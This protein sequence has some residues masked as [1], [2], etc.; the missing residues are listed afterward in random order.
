MPKGQF[1]RIKRICSEE[2]D[3]DFHAQIMKTHFIAR[4]YKKE[5][6]EKTIAEV[7]NL[8]REDLLVDKDVLSEKDPQSVLVCTWHP[9]LNKLPKI[10]R[11]CFEIIASDPKLRKTFTEIPSVAFRRMKN[12]GN[13]LCR[14]D[15]QQKKQPKEAKC[16]GCILCQQ[17]GEGDVLRNNKA[18]TEKQLKSRATCHTEGII[19]AIRCKKCDLIYVA[20]T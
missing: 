14:T 4:G 19:Y 7:R 9:A 16:K 20:I 18:G 15:I 11:E 3:F 5:N 8:K 1:I 17:M 13:H 10:L 2:N 12:T 6:L